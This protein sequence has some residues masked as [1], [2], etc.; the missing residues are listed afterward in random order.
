M[1]TVPTERPNADAP[2]PQDGLEQ[3]AVGDPAAQ[4]QQPPPPEESSAPDKVSN[5]LDGISDV[6]DIADVVTGVFSIFD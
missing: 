3:A 5:V 2:K 4:S 1:T 6:V